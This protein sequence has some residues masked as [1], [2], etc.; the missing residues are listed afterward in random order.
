MENAP[1]VPAEMDQEEVAHLASRYDLVV[2]VPGHAFFTSSFVRQRFPGIEAGT[3]DLELTI[4][5]VEG[6]VLRVPRDTVVRHPDASVAGP[7]N[8]IGLSISPVHIDDIPMP[9]P[10]G[11][12]YWLAMAGET[13]V[14]GLMTM[15]EMAPAGT[16]A[17]WL[18]YIAVD[19][20]DAATA[21]VGETG[22]TV[23]V[24]PFDIPDIGRMSVV[25][26]PQGAV[27]ALVTSA[28]D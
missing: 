20:V 10:D 19:D 25:R 7:G 6:L 24:E 1:V 18:T 4:P 9:M 11:G 3:A 14:G 2:D 23:M 13:R 26:D 17:Y 5:G 27:L 8:A 16:P 28:M 22:G 15:P 12:T 21:K